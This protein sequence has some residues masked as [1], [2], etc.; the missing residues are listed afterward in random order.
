MAKVRGKEKARLKTILMELAK[1]EQ[2]IRHSNGLGGN[3]TADWVLPKLQS[4][5]TTGK[6]PVVAFV[7]EDGSNKC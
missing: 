1:L 4:I 6:M 7:T 2:Q 5:R 3:V